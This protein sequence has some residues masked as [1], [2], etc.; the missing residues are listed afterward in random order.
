VFSDNINKSKDILSSLNKSCI[1]CENNLDYIDLWIMSLCHHNIIC[2]STIG[3]WGAYLNKNKDKYVLYPS[4]MIAF[5]S[6]ITQITN[7]D[8]IKENHLPNNW[9]SINSNS[10]NN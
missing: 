4:D 7:L 6:R 10:I 1:Y 8:L 5:Y 9:I 2:H 3:W